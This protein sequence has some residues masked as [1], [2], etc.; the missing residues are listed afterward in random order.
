[1]LNLTCVVV[2]VGLVTIEIL[3]QHFNDGKCST[4]TS[5]LAGVYIGI[6]TLNLLDH[7]VLCAV[8]CVIPSVTILVSH[9][10]RRCTGNV[11]V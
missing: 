8:L 5:W 9:I 10:V 3:I 7:E 2:G 1:M 11:R 4:F 6:G